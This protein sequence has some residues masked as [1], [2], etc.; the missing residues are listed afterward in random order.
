MRTALCPLDTSKPDR[1][2]G[3]ELSADHEAYNSYMNE[4][5]VQVDSEEGVSGRAPVDD[6]GSTSGWNHERS[7][8]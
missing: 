1:L 7:R 6:S 4:E 3:S 2:T 5:F 8:G